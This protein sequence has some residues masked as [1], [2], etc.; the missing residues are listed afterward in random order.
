[1]VALGERQGTLFVIFYD[2]ARDREIQLDVD[3]DWQL[4]TD[5]GEACVYLHGPGQWRISFADHDVR[6]PY[7]HRHRP[8]HH[9]EVLSLVRGLTVEQARLDSD[10]ALRIGFTAVGAERINLTVHGK[11][12]PNTTHVPWQLTWN[13]PAS[14]TSTFGRGGHADV[15]WSTARHRTGG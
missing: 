4:R 1:M 2:T 15:P 9:L 3:S 13:Q 12:K 14:A 6:G 5:A 10:L 7:R 11:C 8:D